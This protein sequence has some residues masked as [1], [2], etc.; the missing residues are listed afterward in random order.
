MS[1][2][3]G[4]IGATAIAE[5]AILAPAAKREDVTV[6]AVAASDPA[7]VRDF[8]AR[9]RDSPGPRRLWGAGRSHRHNH[10][11]RVVAQFGAPGVGRPGSEGG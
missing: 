6:R 9:Q 5:K 10:G 2:D 8:A 1:L 4:L 3:I 11:V 7:R